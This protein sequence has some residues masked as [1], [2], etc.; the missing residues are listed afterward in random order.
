MTRIELDPTQ[1]PV[2][3]QPAPAPPA[4]A[5]APAAPAPAIAGQVDAVPPGGFTQAYVNAL[6]AKKSELSTQ[7]RSAQSRRDE[8]AKDL[9]TAPDGPARTGLEARL[10]VL[11]TRLAQLE[12]DIAAN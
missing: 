2:S 5:Q 9:R 6:N 7:L 8:V 4:A 3:V 10:G 11:D 1:T 12:T